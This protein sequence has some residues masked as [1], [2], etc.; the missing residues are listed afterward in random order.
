LQAA[1]KCAPGLK[2]ILK[3]EK[4]RVLPRDAI[5]IHTIVSSGSIGSVPLAIALQK[6]EGTSS[7]EVKALMTDGGNDI[8]KL[9]A[10]IDRPGLC[11]SSLDQGKFI[12][13]FEDENLVCGSDSNSG[14]IICWKVLKFDHEKV[15]QQRRRHRRKSGL[16]LWVVPCAK[17]KS[18]TRHKW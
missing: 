3:P 16:L 17:G 2:D 9:C 12:T 18:N 4:N 7:D 15:R 11:S 6:K 10:G 5:D 1:E 13:S 14:G 8:K